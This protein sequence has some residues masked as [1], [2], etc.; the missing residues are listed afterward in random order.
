[1]LNGEVIND[2][3]GLLQITTVIN[4]TSS[5]SMLSVSSIDE[6]THQ[7]MYEC[8]VTNM[9]CSDKDTLYVTGL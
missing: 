9:A 5:V 4:K 2:R 7:G 8:N 1:M 6:A 3:D